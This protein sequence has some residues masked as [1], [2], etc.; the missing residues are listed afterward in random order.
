MFLFI[1][2]FFFLIVVYNDF[3]FDVLSDYFVLL[4]GKIVVCVIDYF[5]L[6]N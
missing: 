3:F 5:L 6:N 2:V 1:Y 4:Y